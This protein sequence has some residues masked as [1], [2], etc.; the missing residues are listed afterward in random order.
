M[1]YIVEIEVELE[2]KLPEDVKRIVELADNIRQAV[3]VIRVLE[4]ED[5]DRFV[6]IVNR[7]RNSL[8]DDLQELAVKISD[9]LG[10]AGTR[11]MRVGV[12]ISEE[13]GRGEK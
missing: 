10:E 7:L 2:V 13:K 5:R 12:Y 4:L 8:K 9:V 1:S 11:V 3:G 6:P